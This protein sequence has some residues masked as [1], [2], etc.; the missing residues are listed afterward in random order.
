MTEQQYYQNLTPPKGPIDCILD[1][2]AY[3]EIDDQFAIAY[4]VRSASENLRI[5]AF[6]AAPFHN[7][8]SASPA[9]GMEKSYQELKRILSLCGANYPI[10]RGSKN[11][12]PDEKTPVLSEAAKDL[13]K[14][15]LD[16]SAEHP[17]YI[18]AIG[19]ITNIASALLLEPKIRE[20][21]VVVWLG[22]HAW[23]YHDTNEF[24]MKQDI[25]AARVVMG[26]GIPFIQLP[27]MGVVNLFGISKPEA[28][29][30]L[31]GKNPLANYLGERIIK[32]YLQKPYAFKVLWDVTAV[33]WL[34]NEEARFMLYRTLPAH[35]PD[36]DHHYEETPS[37][38]PISLVYHIKRQELMED[39]LEK[40]TK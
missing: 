22:G 9:D 19:A 13:A 4:L 17:L 12:L 23:H 21:C 34:L 39:L 7:R 6:Y 1:T 40:I 10:Y 29:Q 16:Y 37:P 27:C 28:E 5:K 25:A 8:L 26:S 18:I 38:Y 14:R 15:A 2:D 36:Y 31:L 3:N 20:N 32:E 30:Y 35:L 11:Y 33:A 24:N